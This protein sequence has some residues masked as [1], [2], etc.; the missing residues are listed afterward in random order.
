MKA[1]K[2]GERIN[3][4]LEFFDKMI[5]DSDNTLYKSVVQSA[6][7]YTFHWI[8]LSSLNIWGVDG[9]DF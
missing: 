6:V 1:F 2:T 4:I 9:W 8:L 5:I 7:M 3:N